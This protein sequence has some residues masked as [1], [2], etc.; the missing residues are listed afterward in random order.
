MHIASTTKEEAL[1]LILTI[2]GNF[3]SSG[4]KK[5]LFGKN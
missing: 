2:N 5:I 1:T 4:R 3:S